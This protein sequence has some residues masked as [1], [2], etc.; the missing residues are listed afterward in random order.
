MALS[1]LERGGGVGGCYKEAQLPVGPAGEE[2]NPSGVQ[3][4]SEL[5]G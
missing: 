4:F 3:S 1:D 5:P 2:R